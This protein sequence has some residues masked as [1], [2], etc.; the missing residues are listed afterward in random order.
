MIRR[1]WTLFVARNKEFLRDRSALAWSILFP[2][3]IILGFGLVFNED[4]QTLYKAG[5]VGPDRADDSFSLRYRAFRK[6]RFVEFVQFK[7][8]E[9]AA[10]KLLHHRIDILIE[11][12]TGTYWK[13]ETSPKGY[14]AEKLL[15]SAGLD[16]GESIFRKTVKGR[17]VPYLEWFFPGILGMNV[18]FSALFGVGYVVVN[19]R[20][21]G[22]LKRMSVTPLRPFEFLSA[23]ILSRMFILIGVT[24]VVFTGCMLL[25]GFSMRGSVFDLLVIYCLGGVSMIS[26]SLLVASRSDSE[27]FAGGILNIITW[28]MMFLSEVWFS[29]EGAAPWIRNVSKIFP[30]THVVDASR[31]IMNDGAGLTDL[32]V[33]LAF[34]AG[35]TVVF[36]AAGS[37]LFKWHRS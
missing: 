28:P 9:E 19:Y 7:T 10:G 1:I 22:V 34:L 2:F 33:Q 24:A 26:L 29:L 4:R 21:N 12:S 25:F 27:E 20:K 17:E 3:L 37:F 32:A 13:S 30:L 36:L 15:L 5:I 8:G 23:Q 14:I 16:T 11:P 35:T 31:R 6:T 18:M